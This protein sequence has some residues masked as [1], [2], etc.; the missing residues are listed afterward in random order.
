M[1]GQSLQECGLESVE[2][3]VHDVWKLWA[4]FGREVPRPEITCRDG[5]AVVRPGGYVE[6]G[7]VAVWGM[8]GKLCLKA[9]VERGAARV[10]LF[11]G[12]EFGGAKAEAILR[13]AVGLSR[14]MVAAGA[15]PWLEEGFV[16]DAH[17]WK[18]VRVSAF[19]RYLEECESRQLRRV[20]MP[21]YVERWA[22]IES[23]VVAP[24]KDF[25]GDVRVQASASMRDARSAAE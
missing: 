12:L 2:R 17:L 15:R 21:M 5:F 6:V 7:E 10:M 16:W 8:A 14:Q 9:G 22:W 18:S 24:W 11:L 20:I 23:F 3:A 13:D 25:W 4:D 1:L 19:A